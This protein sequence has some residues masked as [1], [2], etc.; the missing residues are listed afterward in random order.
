[1]RIYGSGTYIRPLPH[2][3]AVT[4]IFPPRAV[5]VIVAVAVL[6]AVLLGI[7]VRGRYE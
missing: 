5:Y 1:M 2:L 6:L 3:S 7:L 4:H